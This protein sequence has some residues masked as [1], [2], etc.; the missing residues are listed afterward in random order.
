MA[1]AGSTEQESLEIIDLD[2]LD[3][4]FQ[5]DETWLVQPISPSNLQRSPD[6]AQF[7]PKKTDPRKVVANVLTPNFLNITFL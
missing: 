6:Q 7:L 2:E 3:L 4:E 1:E 5:D